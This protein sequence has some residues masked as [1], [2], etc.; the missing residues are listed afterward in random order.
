M[1]RISTSQDYD[2]RQ[3]LARSSVADLP[4]A[5]KIM[6]QCLHRSVE[7]RY[8]F[9]DGEIACAWGLIPP[10]ILSSV[11]Y[12]WLLTTDVVAEHKFLFIR[13]SQRYIEEA[14]KEFPII[15]GDAIVGNDPAIR[16]LKWLGAEFLQPDGQRIPFVIR[17]K[18]G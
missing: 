3:V 17:A 6:Q 2:I 4:E 18:N 8:G 16:W 13:H 5:E 1:I 11:A 10:T 7:I 12:L 9:I 15:V 14:L